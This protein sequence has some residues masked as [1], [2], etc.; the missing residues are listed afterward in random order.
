MMGT[1][2]SRRRSGT[3]T[4]G[5]FKRSKRHGRMLNRCIARTGRS[6]YGLR[7]DIVKHTILDE[8]ANVWQVRRSASF[9][10][11]VYS[12]EGAQI[13]VDAWMERMQ[14]VGSVWDAHGRSGTEFPAKC[15]D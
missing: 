2:M 14:F 8:L 9:E 6:V 15:H 4:D 12:V 1:E 10:Y 11:N 7:V 13:L 3:I 5:S